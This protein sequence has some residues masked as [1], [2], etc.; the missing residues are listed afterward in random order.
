LKFCRK[1]TFIMQI[2][3]NGGPKNEPA[4]FFKTLQKYIAIMQNIV[5]FLWNYAEYC[6][7]IV[8]LCWILCIICEI[9]HYLWNYALFVKLCII[10]EIMHY[11]W[12]YALFVKLCIICEMMHYLWNYALFV[13]L[14]IICEIMHYLWNYALFVKLCILWVY[15]SIMHLNAKLCK[16]KYG[17]FSLSYLNQTFI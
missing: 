1:Y 17:I 4:C 8:K 12:N 14:C 9:M 2:V 6:S 16:K 13:K 10:C 3:Q 5:H 11:L 15:N 7:F